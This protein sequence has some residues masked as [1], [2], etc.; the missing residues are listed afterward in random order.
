MQLK[1]QFIETTLKL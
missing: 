1:Q